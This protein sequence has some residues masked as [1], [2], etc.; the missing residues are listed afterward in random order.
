MTRKRPIRRDRVFLAA[1]VVLAAILVPILFLRGRSPAPQAAV[2]EETSGSPSAAASQA[3]EG[4]QTAPPE[5]E[6]TAS[7]S[8]LDE[9]GN[10]QI[11]VATQAL[12]LI[13]TIQEGETLSGIAVELGVSVEG[14]MA[15]NRILSPESV[16]TGQAVRVSHLGLLHIIKAGQTLSDIALEYGIPVQEIAAANGITDA[17]TIYAGKEIIVPGASPS[18]WG[19]VVRLSQGQ[20]T[21]FINPVQGKRV[22]LF[23]YQDD[24]DL[25]W[26]D[27]QGM[28]IDVP[29]GTTVR[30]AAAGHVYFVGELDGPGTLVVI[31]HTD[32]YYSTYAH[33]S[34]TLV[35]VG[36]FVD[37]GQAIA[38][39][40]NS[41][42]SSGPHLHFEIR[43]RDFPVDPL[44]YLP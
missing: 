35:S 23:G 14:L 3:T 26:R 1:L 11:P 9:T 2:S 36:Q 17:E 16:A 43:T 42:V 24:P 31:E 13:H 34:K 40:G 33:L 20:A 32:G 18:I 29:V 38:E 41:G 6:L 28:D 19:E 27:H 7:V 5:G 15:S 4:A 39:S 30:A 25:G 37:T 22:A 44:R 10:E 8:P 12:I 21:R